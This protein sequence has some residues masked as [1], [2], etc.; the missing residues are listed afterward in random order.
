M[1]TPPVETSPSP[2]LKTLSAQSIPNI[3]QQFTFS[4][5]IPNAWIAEPISSINAVNFYNPAADASTSL[6]KSQIF[7][8]YFEASDFLTLSTVDILSKSSLTVGNRPAVRYTIK[9]KPNVSNFPNQPSWRNK[10]HVVTDVRVSDTNPS[11]FYVIAKN[12]ELDE[13]TY[14][15]LLDSFTVK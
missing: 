9:K 5:T 3:A 11:V 6:E 15:I 12:P 7:I 2:T 10:E 4:A 1:A 8:R 13:T 14:Q